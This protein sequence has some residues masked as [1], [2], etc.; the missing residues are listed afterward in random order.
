MLQLFKAIAP[1]APPPQQAHQNQFCCRSSAAQVMVHR[2]WVLQGR[3][4]QPPQ[5]Q[6]PPAGLAFLLG[7]QR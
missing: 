6:L 2:R 7:Q 4:I 5:L 1:M 3:Q